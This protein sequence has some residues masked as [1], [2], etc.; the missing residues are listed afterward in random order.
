MKTKTDLKRSV[1]RMQQVKEA[2]RKELVKRAEERK[3]ATP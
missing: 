3:K 2:I 1:Q